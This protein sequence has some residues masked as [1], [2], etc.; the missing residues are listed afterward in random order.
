M[1]R[2]PPAAAAAKWPCA[3][4]RVPDVR[5]PGHPPLL[6]ESTG[7]A[8]R[9]GGQ[10]GAQ[11]REPGGFWFSALRP[12]LPDRHFLFSRASPPPARSAPGRGPAAAPSGLAGEGGKAAGARRPSPAAPPLPPPPRRPD[13]FFHDCIRPRAVF[14]PA[15]P[16][17]ACN[18]ARLSP[19]RRGFSRAQ[20][21]PGGAPSPPLAPAFSAGPRD[22]LRRAELSPFAP[23][24]PSCPRRGGLRPREPYICAQSRPSP[25]PSASALPEA[26]LA[27]R[28][29]PGTARCGAGVRRVQSLQSPAASASC[30]CSGLTFLPTGKRRSRGWRPGRPHRGG[31][32][33]RAH[34]A[35]HNLRSSCVPSAHGQLPGRTH[36][37]PRES[38]H[39]LGQHFLSA[40]FSTP[41]LPPNKKP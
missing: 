39:I 15:V 10:A 38:E 17:R 2:P 34:S 9:A 4:S 32:P 37:P 36:P 16:G 19:A 20:Q 1:G 41:P 24:R 13:G 5:Q 7:R 26:L 31:A 25:S 6:V 29:L 18:L 30:L 12:L 33:R 14:V 27:P 8:P 22:P 28:L 11:Y 21:E 40:I 3:A 23:L 35:R